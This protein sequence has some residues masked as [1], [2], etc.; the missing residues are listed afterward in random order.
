MATIKVKLG[1]IL[2][3]EVE[4]IVCP[5]DTQFSLSGL[6]G[7]R[8]KGAETE[9]FTDQFKDETLPLGESKIVRAYNIKSKN[10]IFTSCPRFNALKIDGNNLDILRRAYYSALM[11]ADINRI[12]S[13]SIPLLSSGN[14]KCPPAKSFEI[15]YEMLNHF[16]EANQYNGE[17]NIVIGTEQDWK[18][19]QYFIKKHGFEVSGD[20]YDL[21]LKPSTYR[22][23]YNFCAPQPVSFKNIDVGMTF[24]QLLKHYQKLKGKKDKDVYNVAFGKN[25][26]SRSLFFKYKNNTVTPQKYKIILIALALELSIEDTNHLLSSA[27]YVFSNGIKCDV[28][29]KRC[30]EN[31][32][33]NIEEINCIL[34]DNNCEILANLK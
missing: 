9:I 27:G 31:S 20:Q 4:A 34:Q 7:E 17:I 29:I 11:T 10:V 30:I 15:A 28:I 18:V 8:I 6:I 19:C 14:N 5:T 23:L 21:E 1:D 25:S 26:N 12:E 24:S 2:D 33:L 22:P 3:G 32:I 13:I 16:L